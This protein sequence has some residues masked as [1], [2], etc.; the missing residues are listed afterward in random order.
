MTPGIPGTGIGGLFYMLSAAALPLREGYHRMWRGV[1]AARWRVIAMQ[2]LLAAGILGGMWTTGWLLGVLLSTARTHF[3]AGPATA[4]HNV[5]RTATFALSFATLIL[6]VCTVELMGVWAR[7]RARRRERL[8][9]AQPTPI[10]RAPRRVAA[11]G[12]RG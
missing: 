3:V 4:S 12:S 9:S 8:A 5:W 11:G 7:R 10:A 6:V 2:Q 1:A